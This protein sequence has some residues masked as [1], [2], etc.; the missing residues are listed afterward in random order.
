MPGRPWKP[1]ALKPHGTVA[2]ARRHYRRNEKPCEACLWAQNQAAAERPRKGL[3]GH[4]PPDKRWN[5]KVAA[6]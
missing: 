5:K 6:Q 2:A 1:W 4:H 3:R